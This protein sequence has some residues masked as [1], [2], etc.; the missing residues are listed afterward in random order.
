MRSPG[1]GVIS[2][3]AFEWLAASIQ[4]RLLL[5]PMIIVKGGHG[6]FVRTGAEAE[7]KTGLG[8]GAWQCP[9]VVRLLRPH[10][11]RRESV[12]QFPGV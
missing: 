12:T 5:S 11:L 10:R 9:I 2:L 1:V 7:A 8:L 3:P 4:G 6:R